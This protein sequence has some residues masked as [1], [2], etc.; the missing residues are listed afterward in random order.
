LSACAV[1]PH[2]R[3]ALLL[4]SQCTGFGSLCPFLSHH[5]LVTLDVCAP[6]DQAPA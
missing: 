5:L 4:R 6:V 1:D 3:I 2:H